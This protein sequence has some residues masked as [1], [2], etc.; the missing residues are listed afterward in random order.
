MHSSAVSRQAQVGALALQ[1]FADKTIDD[2][3]SSVPTRTTVNPG[4]PVE[5]AKRWQPHAG[6][7]RRRTWLP[8]AAVLVYSLGLPV[9]AIEAVGK[10][11]L[12]VPFDAMCWQ[13]WHQQIRAAIGSAAR[14]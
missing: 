2:G 5:S 13:S 11:A 7:K 4:R 10:I 12:T 1:I 14:R 9:I 6:Q 3:L 8:V